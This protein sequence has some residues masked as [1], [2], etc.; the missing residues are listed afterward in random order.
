MSKMCIDPEVYRPDAHSEAMGLR[1]T[2]QIR[3]ERLW[4]AAE[5]GVA[6]SHVALCPACAELLASFERMRSV[7]DAKGGGAV[8]IAA[9]PDGAALSQYYYGEVG[10]ERGAGIGAHLKICTEC[11]QDLA[12]LARSQEP[13]ER[14]APARRRLMWM[15]VAA[16]ALVASIISARWDRKPKPEEPLGFTPS[17]QYASMAKM[18]PLDRAELLQDSP[19]GHHPQ[20][21]QVLAAYE[22][23]DYKKAAEYADIVV[24]AVQDPSGEY[25]LGMSLYHEG[26]QVEAYRA[27]RASERMSPQTAYRCWTMLQFALLMGDKKTVE[28]EAH[29][30]GEDP[31]YAPRCQQI[32]TQIT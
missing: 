12:F 16:G 8:T 24:H 4:T 22:K 11:R 25:L 20:L 31:A 13:R 9:C 32:L 7:L 27:I 21:E 23:G 29:H 17:A 26:K 1:D 28:R 18:P 3:H 10:G 30:A 6:P 14:T 19:A 5:T 15:A 2:E